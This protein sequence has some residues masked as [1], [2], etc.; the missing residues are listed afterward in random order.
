MLNLHWTLVKYD[1]QQSSLI[2]TK[3]YILYS[4]ITS[5]YKKQRSIN[6]ILIEL[7]Y[8]QKIKEKWR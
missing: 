7:L 3:L 5:F 1:N 8:K 4:N 6:E 2:L